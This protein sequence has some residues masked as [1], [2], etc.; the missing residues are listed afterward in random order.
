MA[1][2]TLTGHVDDQHRLTA[3]VPD[4]IPLRPEADLYLL[5]DIDVPWA[6]DGT[7]YFPDDIDRR[8]FMA[9]CED[10]LE[11]A[12]ARWNLISGAWDERLDRAIAAVEALGAP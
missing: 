1:I 8:R 11:R 5:F 9:A 12:G 10:V 2:L 3:H 4:T 7:R 6:D